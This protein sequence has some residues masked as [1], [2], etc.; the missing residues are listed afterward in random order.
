MRI[1]EFAL[2]NDE[3]EYTLVVAAEKE[4]SKYQPLIAAVK[5]LWP[6]MLQILA[7]FQAEFTELQQ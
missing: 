1:A 2:G 4:D 7:K 6:Q 3:D 5:G